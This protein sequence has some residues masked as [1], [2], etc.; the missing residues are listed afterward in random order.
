MLPWTVAGW[1]SREIRYASTERD[2]GTWAWDIS[3]PIAE[4][5]AE[6]A[7]DD[8]AADALGIDLDSVVLAFI[9]SHGRARTMDIVEDRRVQRVIT[10]LP[11]SKSA[12]RWIDNSLQRLRKSFQIVAT[13]NR[14]KATT[15]KVIP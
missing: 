5:L 9:R 4:Q 7:A 8:V 11:H 15:T 1:L 2:I 12:K 3:R 13:S 6:T 10:K 14:W